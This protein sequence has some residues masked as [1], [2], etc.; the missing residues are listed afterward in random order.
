MNDDLW[1]HLSDAGIC[2][3]EDKSGV[4]IDKHRDLLKTRRSY[5]FD[6]LKLNGSDFL[7]VYVAVG[8]EGKCDI[9]INEILFSD[10]VG[11]GAGGVAESLRNKLMAAL[12]TFLENRGDLT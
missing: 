4:E 8:L 7:N 11:L 1:Q 10:S 12:Q 9:T 2:H 5:F 6:C 3:C